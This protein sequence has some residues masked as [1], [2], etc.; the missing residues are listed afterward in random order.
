M[1]APASVHG[2]LIAYQGMG[3]LIMGPSGSFKTRL[4]I[5]SM[6]HGAKF[7]ADDQVVLSLTMGMLMGGP[8]PGFQGVLELRGVG[9]MKLPDSATQQV[10]HTVV[11]LTPVEQIERLP[12]AREFREFLGIQVPLIRMAPPPSSSGALLLS[13]V[14]WVQEGRLLPSDWRPG[15]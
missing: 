14:K 6:M 9:L 13:A 3:I 11:E 2:S 10:V 5:E 15:A 8:R 12:V 4:C 1:N 7:I